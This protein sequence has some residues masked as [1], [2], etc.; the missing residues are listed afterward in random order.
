[1]QHINKDVPRLLSNV[2]IL[3]LVLIIAFSSFNVKRANAATNDDALK[4]VINF[5]NAEKS[6]NVDYMINSS[7]YFRKI[8]NVKEFYNRICSEKPLQQAR[9]TKFSEV[10]ENLALVSY[11]SIYNDMIFIKTSPI[12]KKEGEWKI[13]TGIP[14][15]GYI[16]SKTTD[17]RNA[18]VVKVLSDFSKAIKN[19]DLA[20]MK[21][22]IKILQDTNNDK[23]EKHLKAISEGPE[24]PEVTT[25]WMEF[26]S[27]NLAFVQTE[28]KYRHYRHTQNLIMCKEKGE[29]KVVYGHPLVNSGIPIGDKTIEIK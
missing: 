12:I 24:A 16:E 13:V 8:T 21:K 29:W 5:L 14:G 22:H 23:L 27:E 2:V 10:N 9:I 26:I 7:I 19:H 18:E 20:K 1:M 4:T 15:N 6:C 25:N 11:E 28:T 17:N 3:G